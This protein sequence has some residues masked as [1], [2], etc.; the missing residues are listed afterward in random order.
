MALLHDETGTA[1]DRRCVAA[2]ERVLSREAQPEPASVPLLR[3]AA[4]GA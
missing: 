2:L 4:A 1:F 3:I